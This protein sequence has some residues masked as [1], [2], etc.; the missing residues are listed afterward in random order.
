[1]NYIVQYFDEIEKKSLYVAYYNNALYYGITKGN[2]R[3]VLQSIKE[4]N[5]N[6][7]LEWSNGIKYEFLSK[8]KPLQTV[9]N[10]SIYKINYGD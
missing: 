9:K 10:V 7:F 6:Y 5:I 1:M 2:D 4:N 8:Q 3:E